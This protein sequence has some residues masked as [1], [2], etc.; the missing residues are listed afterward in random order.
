MKTFINDVINIAYERHDMMQFPQEFTRFSEFYYT[1]RCK[2]IMEIGSCL[3]GTFYV[4]CK[5]S[6]PAGLKISVDYP[7][8]KNQKEDMEAKNVHSK[9]KTFSENVHII[10]GDSHLDD[11]KNKVLATLNGEQLD[12]LFIDGDHTY[13]GVKKDY[14]MYAEFVKKGGYI[15]FHDINDT[16]IHRNLQCNVSKFWNELPAKRTLQFNSKSV[17]MGLGVIQVI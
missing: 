16:E 2:N 9:M 6:H 5:L 13:E 15:G 10:V 12:F 4:L 8:Y 14:E 7:F 11:T 1:L 17:S 3:G